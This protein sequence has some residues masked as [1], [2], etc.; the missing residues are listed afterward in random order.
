MTFIH[1]ALLSEGQT[2]IEK[3]KLPKVNSLPKIYASKNI[4]VL[5]GGIGKENTNSS[6]KYIFDNYTI[7]KAINIGIAGCS[8]TTIEIGELFCTNRELEDI[9]SMR[10]ETV[11]TPQ[12]PTTNYP[13]NTLYDM[14]ASYFLAV[15]K[16]H[17]D[18]KNIYIFKIVSDHLDSTI[19]KKEFVKKLINDK[20][21]YISKYL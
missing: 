11:D 16:K 4:I 8:D 3:Y 2:F 9:N 21:R 1:T 19:P 5:I 18:E 20:F 10:C 13:I 7:T 17:L 12:L 15:V 6:L 14:E